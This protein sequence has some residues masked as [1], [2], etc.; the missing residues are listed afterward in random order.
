MQIRFVI[1]SVLI[2]MIPAFGSVLAEDNETVNLT[3][4]ING[5][6][7]IFSFSP[8]VHLDD[9]AARNT[10]GNSTESQDL[11]EEIS[12]E[13]KYNLISQDYVHTSTPLGFL[14][15]PMSCHFNTC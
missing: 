14:G 10:S 15:I 3:E 5:A 6:P 13:A 2:I 4:P 1:L 12:L 11:E 8:A 7:I 9:E